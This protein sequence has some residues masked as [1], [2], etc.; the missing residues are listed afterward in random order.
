MKKL[1]AI[2]MWTILLTIAAVAQSKEEREVLKFIADYDQAYVNQDISFA[3][4]VWPAE[5]IFSAADGSSQN[6]AKA[7]EEARADKANPKY[8]LLS[9]KSVNDSLRVMGNTAIVSGTWTSSTVPMGD[10]QAEPH[11]DRGRYTMVLEKRKGGWVILAEHISEAQHDKKLMEAAV[12]KASESYNQIMTRKD[13]AAYERLF[14]D[15]FISTFDNGKVNNKAEEIAHRVSSDL[16]IE[17]TTTADQKVQ[18]IGNNAALET[19]TYTTIGVSKSRPFTE[20]GRYTTTWI[21]RD[22]RW[23]ITADHSSKISDTNP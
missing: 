20:K 6:R 16:K 17:T 14:A 13:R 2:A 3:E 12:L 19:G 23:Q 21:F 1:V 9:I 7:L 5:Y 15:E 11:I 4:R 10:L 22:G 18:I 8:K